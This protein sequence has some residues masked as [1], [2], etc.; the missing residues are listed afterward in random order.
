MCLDKF[1]KID[2][3]SCARFRIKISVNVDEKPCSSVQANDGELVAAQD[4]KV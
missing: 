1:A 3:R 4:E 2:R